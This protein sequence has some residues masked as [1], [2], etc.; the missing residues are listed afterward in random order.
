[1]RKILLMIAAVALLGACRRANPEIVSAELVPITA[2]SVVADSAMLQLIA[3]YKTAQAVEMNVVIG[4][5]DQLMRAELPE[6]LL[7]A[8]VSDAMLAFGNALKP[9]DMAITNF[10]GLRNDLPQGAVTVGHVLQI[11]PFD[12]A[13][14]FI[15]LKGADMRRLA[16]AIAAKGGEVE[17]GMTLTIRNGKAENVSVG[18][19]PIDDERIYRIITTDYLSYGSDHLEPLADYTHIEGLGTM[20][21]DA[22]TNYIRRETEAGHIIHANL[23]HQIH[24]EK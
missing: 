11:M 13:L 21:R 1:M 24:V 12:N 18:G 3:P 16:D 20:L 5:S 6:G 7:N 15:E 9:T 14:V 23:K 2:D 4:E 17:T 8:F 10:G 19:C 22:L